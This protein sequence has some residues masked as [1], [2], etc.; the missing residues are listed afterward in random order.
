MHPTHPALKTP[1]RL[2]SRAEFRRHVGRF[3]IL[4]LG[5]LALSLGVGILGYH[6]V[7]GLHWI[8]SL[9]NAS[10]ILTGMGPVDRMDR[11]AAQLFASA[12][13]ILRAAADPASL[14]A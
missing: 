5:G 7:V 9:L 14:E 1:L 13:A 4:A 2:R 6:Y 3:L 12:S 8:D 11:D 10:M